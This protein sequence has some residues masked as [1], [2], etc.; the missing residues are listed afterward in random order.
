MAEDEEIVFSFISKWKR[1]VE[2]SLLE[3]SILWIKSRS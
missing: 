1:R 3:D 2:P